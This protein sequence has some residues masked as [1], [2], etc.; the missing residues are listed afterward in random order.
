MTWQ[1]A[2]LRSEMS[3]EAMG[4][5]CTRR[6]DTYHDWLRIRT[7][8]PDCGSGAYCMFDDSA[9]T[10]YAWDRAVNGL[11]PVSGQSDGA[12]YTGIWCQFTEGNVSVTMTLSRMP[13]GHL[14]PGT[15][16]GAILTASTGGKVY[17]YL[18]ITLPRLL[19]DRGVGFRYHHGVSGTSIMITTNAEP[20]RN[21]I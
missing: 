7:P 20:G 13:L 5:R 6:G 16:W 2:T 14:G 4:R 21:A 17:R 19:N 3:E 12:Y 15:A 8:C 11:K 18:R 9:Y 10:A 1:I